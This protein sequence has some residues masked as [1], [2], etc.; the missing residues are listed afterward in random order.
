M[1]QCILLPVSA[2]YLRRIFTSSMDGKNGKYM[3]NFT[4]SY[5]NPL[6]R[7]GNMHSCSFQRTVSADN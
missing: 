5:K 3:H 1:P 6:C 7:S 2:I 4:I